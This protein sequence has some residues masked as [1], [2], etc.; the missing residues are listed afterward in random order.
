MSESVLSVNI[1]ADSNVVLHS[2][3]EMSSGSGT[4]QAAH[5]IAIQ[6]VV[7][8]DTSSGEDILSV[9]HRSTVPTKPRTIKPQKGVIKSFIT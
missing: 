3:E 4:T 9:E 7:P 2:H 1:Y 5:G 6:E 8:P